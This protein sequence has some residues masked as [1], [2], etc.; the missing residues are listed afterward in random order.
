MK[1]FLNSVAAMLRRA[2]DPESVKKSF[3]QRHS[4]QNGVKIASYLAWF[5]VICALVGIL[6]PK[7]WLNG[8]C[9]L[10]V[11][12]WFWGYRVATALEKRKDYLRR[13]WKGLQIAGKA[14]VVLLVVFLLMV[15]VAAVLADGDNAITRELP[16]LKEQAKEF[17][18][19]LNELIDS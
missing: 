1:N 5:F 3:L 10:L 17:L 8:L 16:A 14:M 7:L 6:S 12:F 13:T 15:I 11:A 18:A 9:C 4:K 19:H 2:T